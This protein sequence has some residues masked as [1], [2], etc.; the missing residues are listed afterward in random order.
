MRGIFT[1]ITESYQT[2]AGASEVCVQ[3]GTE[4]VPED[5]VSVVIPDAV[6]YIPLEDLVDFE[7][8]KERLTKEKEKLEKELA[9]SKGMLSNEKFLN[10]APAE[11]VAEERAKMDKYQQ[12]MD[13]VLARLAQMK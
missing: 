11:K 8:E 9:R 10:K 13:D 6:M 4:G 3:A 7:K 1:E 5:A 2:L 12:M